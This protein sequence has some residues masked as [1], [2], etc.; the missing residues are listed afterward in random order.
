ML[1]APLV[2]LVALVAREASAE[3]AVS[4]VM[5]KTAVPV[6]MVDWLATAQMEAKLVMVP[7]VVSAAAAVSAV[8]Q[9]LAASAGS[10][11]PVVLADLGAAAV[12][13]AMAA[14]VPS[15]AR[16]ASAELVRLVESAAWEPMEE[17]VAME[18][19]V[20]TVARA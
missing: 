10:V 1:T 16:A 3:M 18:L 2:A 20:V 7:L 5:V 19:L 9:V 6:V 11:E 14:L 15:A 8:P 4:E 12:K 17:P 13:A